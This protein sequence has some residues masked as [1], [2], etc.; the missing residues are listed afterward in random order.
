MQ[1]NL[2][3]IFF[4]LSLIICLSSKQ[5]IAQTQFVY[6]QLVMI[7]PLWATMQDVDPAL[8]TK[9]AAPLNE[10]QLIQQHLHEVEKLLRSRSVKTLSATTK[11]S[12]EKNLNTLRA[13]CLNGVFPINN[14][15]ESRQP[16][17]IDD[18][19]TYCA[20]G[21]LMKTNG[22]DAIA[23]DIRKTQN[24]SYLADINH[25]K[26]MDWVAQSG[27]SFDE[28][29]LIQPGYGP[30]KPPLIS[31]MHYNNTGADQD[32]YIE[33]I[34]GNYPLSNDCDT[35][36]FY[37]HLGNLY[38][39]LPV[40]SMQGIFGYFYYEFPLNE[41]F[42]D[43]GTIKL[44]GRSYTL[45]GAPRDTLTKYIYN[46]TGISMT[47][48]IG[49]TYSMFFPVV[50]DDNTPIGSTLN[51]CGNF[52][53]NWNSTIFP[54]S[55]STLNP[56]VILP[57]TLSEF[58][59]S[60]DNKTIH[61]KW[62]TATELNVS[63]YQIER[64]NDGNN[65]ISIGKVKKSEITSTLKEYSFD[66]NSPNY[67]N[68]YRLKTVDI[69]GSFSYSKILY[70]KNTQASLLVL[71]QNI[72]KDQLHISVN[73][74]QSKIKNI[75]IYDFGGRIISNPKAITGNQWINTF[76]FAKGKYLIRLYTKDGQVYTQQFIK[77]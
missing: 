63:H 11:K 62:Q 46:S 35:I 26:L 59:S 34:Q 68:H 10:K 49:P 42:A 53:N 18:N 52:Y 66:D 19:N 47:N 64:S 20:V 7:N 67:I 41:H 27:L 25:P 36:L 24:Y 9:A 16:Y 22:G 57:V 13:Y 23:K 44:L 1:K 43:S 21:Y 4:V 70:V 48:L 6:D 12:R 33:I 8:K 56:C 14:L 37:D 31:E 77:Q 50:E 58:T 73:T 72:V 32:E 5:A 30:P 69:N 61:L 74:A 76:G 15:H 40:A 29:A 3:Q 38:K 51:F 2:P 54:A 45:L 60:I 75:T 55:I 17:F 28:L 39:T 65:F 71:K